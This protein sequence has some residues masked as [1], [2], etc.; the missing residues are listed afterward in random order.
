MLKG[1][2]EGIVRGVR[3]IS[4]HG[5]LSVDVSYVYAD[6]PDGP[7][8]VARIGPESIDGPLEPGDR[9]SLDYLVGVVTTIR[10]LR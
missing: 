4:V 3:P 5:Q 6:D 9:V 10:K 7:V 2:R 1:S 8:S